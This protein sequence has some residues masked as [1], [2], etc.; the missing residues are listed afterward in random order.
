LLS[1][2]TE[3]LPTIPDEEYADRG[4]RLQ[5]LVAEEGL[6]VLLVNSSE[7]DFANVRYLTD[8]WPVFE[9][10]GVVVPPDGPLTLLIGPESETFARDRSRLDRIRMLTEYRE[11]ADP[12]YPDIEVDT[13]AA[14]FSD[15][16]VASPRRIGIG[17]SF[18]TNYIMLEELRRTF[19]DAE[20]VRADGLL[21]T[22]RSV[23][24]EAEL[25]CLRAAFRI[26]EEAIGDIL[27]VI[28]PGMAELQVVG[29]AQEAIYRRGAEYEGMVQYVMSGRNSRHAI[30]RASY[31][32][33]RAGEV[34]QLNIS[35]RVAGYSSGV[36]RPIVLGRLDPEQ[37]KILD[38][39]LEAH[40]AT[41]SWLRAGV[42]ASDVAKRY[43]AYFTERGREDLYLYGPCHGLGLIEV[44]PPWME[45]TSDY[46][47][48][49]NMTFQ[50]DTFALSPTF[51][52]RWENGARITSDGIELLSNQRMEVIEI[53]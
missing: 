38:F 33:L 4:R 53:D 8:Y 26:S 22:L 25:A 1:E 10:A 18:A 37:R 48:V 42:I 15:A 32:V 19:P 20:L 40:N 34:V 44:E 11:S 28:R 52:A 24:S 17:G 9:S 36:G 45:E 50:I 3:T 13:Y 35:A 43:R 2:P 46:P 12:D 5:S 29:V 49:E 31:R 51:G 7:S 21:T 16:G 6:D 47:L 14:V 23:K 41:A 30:S 27:E 39:G